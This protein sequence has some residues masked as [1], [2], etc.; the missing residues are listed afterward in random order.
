MQPPEALSEREADW[1]SQWE[2]ELTAT[3]EARAVEL[4]KRTNLKFAFGGWQEAKAEKEAKEAQDREGV[5]A[6]CK[7]A[8]SRSPLPL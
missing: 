3:D 1:V 5:V 4:W 2:A 6:H 8:S 7:E